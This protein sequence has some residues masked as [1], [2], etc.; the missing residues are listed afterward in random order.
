MN[1]FVIIGEAFR[2]LKLNRLRTGLTMLGMIIGVAAVVLML[3]IG[4][5][6]QININN[7]IA[8]MG[9]HL[10][11]IVPGATSS[12]GL[13]FG[14]GSVRTL[15]IN[16]AQAVAELPSIEATAPVISG[17][18][19][20]SYNANNWSTSITGVTPDY[21]P[22]SNWAVADGS[23]F[24]EADLRS[25]I[26]VAVLGK[27][28][29]ENLF[30]NEDPI[31]R[32]FRIANKPFLVVG[33]LAIKGQSLSGRDQDDNVFIPITTAQRQ[34]LGNQF[35]GS[36][37][38]MLVQAK[39]S[40]TLDEAEAEITQLL[41]QRHRITDKMENDFTVRNLTALATVASTTA[42]V[43]AWMLG[44]IASISL[45]VGGIGIM[46]IMLVSVT[47]RTRE[48]GIRMAIGASYRII[49]MQFLLEAL[50]ICILGGL[51]GVALGIGGAWMVSQST[52][53]PIVVTLNMIGLAFIFVT[54][55]GIFFGFYPARKAAALKPV[56]ALRYE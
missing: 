16:D 43:M 55:I 29:A 49:L 23:I 27:V 40:D 51:M 26:R 45:L 1:L 34:I 41:R 12:G 33:I 3:S 6:A 18:A 17:I 20:L 13:R 53:M 14:S 24:A 32:T 56:D 5:G 54:V 10:L 48:I 11:I 30:G 8:S 35:P 19:Q 46:N 50:F 42:K 39:S 28:T 4:Q 2:A 37:N 38:H 22:V 36:I 47:E 44:A 52:D 21:F 25:A 7:T 31:G 9:S 15:T